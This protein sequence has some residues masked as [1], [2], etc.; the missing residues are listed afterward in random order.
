MSEPT[1]PVDPRHRLREL[2]A[3]PERDRT[4]AEWDEMN[5]LEIQLA[6]CNRVGG[7]SAE[8]SPMFSKPKHQQPRGD[9]PNPGQNQNRKNPQGK[10]GFPGKHFSKKPK[11][12]P[13]QV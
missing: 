4:D 7:P 5:E 8:R 3:I 2:S 12:P 10:R 13:P 6:P 9:N 1:P 11:A